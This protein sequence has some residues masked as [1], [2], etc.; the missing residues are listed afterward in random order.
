MDFLLF[1]L[2]RATFAASALRRAKVSLTFNNFVDFSASEGRVALAAS[3]FRLAKMSWALV[4]FAAG[5]AA[6]A[7]LLNLLF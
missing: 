3:A 5:S 2:G 4:L 1:P 7:V 6:I